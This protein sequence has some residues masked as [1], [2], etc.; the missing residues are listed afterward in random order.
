MSPP[1]TR[2]PAALE[3]PWCDAYSPIPRGSPAPAAARGFATHRTTHEMN[4]MSLSAG[5]FLRLAAAC[6]AVFLLA[7]CG[8]FSSKEDEYVER[9]PEELYNTGLAYMQDQ[10]YNKA[11]KAFD[12]VDRQHP[13]SPWATQAQLMSAYA[14]YLQDKYDDALISLGR[15]I[16]LHPGNK[17]AAYAY[18]LKAICYYEQIV[19]VGRD[20][21][22][23]QLAF[24]A[25]NDVVTRF[26][27]TDY[28]RDAAL[29]LDL[30]RDHLAGK[31]MEV[32]RFYLE[33]KQYLAAI[34][35]F[36]R[37]I[38]LYQTTT[39]V[40]EALERLTECYLAIGIKDEAQNAAAVLGYNYPGTD[41]YQDSYNLLTSADLKPMKKEGSWLSAVF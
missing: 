29:K 3:R 8:L 21:K 19:D 25:L 27:N 38:E 18:Y 16:D 40:P 22:N 39:H 4:I 17:C 7:G 24:D 11:A 13:Y 6:A 32:G 20:Q 31:E 34:N 26:P 15:F 37:V 2:G 36:R 28:A 10:E 9:P 30:A 33:R 35:R 41:W 14:N 5:R 23:T 12:E 1:S